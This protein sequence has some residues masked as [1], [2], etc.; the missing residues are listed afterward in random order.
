[1]KFPNKK[2]I[3]EVLNKITDDDFSYVLPSDASHVDKTKHELC[4]KFVVYLRDEKMSQ[5]EL[6]RRIGVDRSRINW[7]V[8]YRIDNFTID[9]LYE[10]W[11]TIEP[12]FELKV[13]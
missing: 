8:K 7:I 4:K 6:A 12:E 2:Q 13:S 3:E 11:S 10:L 1:M 9:K 5:A